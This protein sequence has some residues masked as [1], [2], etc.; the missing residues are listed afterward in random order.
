MTK[1]VSVVVTC[2]NHQAYIK[3][4]L[5]SLFDQ[6]YSNIELLVFN[7]GSTDQSG[8]IIQET[9]KA[10][11]FAV[12][13]YHEHANQGIVKTRNQAFD[14]IQGDYLLFV[15]SDNYLPLNFIESVVTTAE[16]AQA[17]LVYTA[18][19]NADDGT[20][21]NPIR[22]FDL[23]ELYFGNYMDNCSLVRVSAIKTARYDDQLPKLVDYDF[24]MNLIIKQGAKAVACPDTFIHYRV[25]T[26]SISAHGNVKKYYRAYSYILGKY[27]MDHPQLAYRALQKHFDAFARAEQA[28]IEASIR[29]EQFS[30]YV[31]DDK[32]HEQTLLWQQPVLFE[33]SFELK[34]GS[35]IPQLR[36][37]P[38]RIPSFY[39]VL[40]VTSK[41]YGT[42]L[43]P[44][45]TNGTM[46]AQ[47]FVFDDFHPYIDY[48]LTFYQDDVLQVTYQRYNIADITSNSQPYI[49]TALAK[50]LKA[51]TAQHHAA[52]LETA[53][54]FQ[55]LEV[56]HT[57]ALAKKQ[58]ELDKL[59]VAYD[60]LFAQYH[61]T[62]GSRRWIYPTKLLN[63]LRRKK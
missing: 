37:L 26:T 59:Q 60:Q 33:E 61:A 19:V 20:V 10:S 21:V 48:D 35:E 32:E 39:Q 55:T 14:Q 25:L 27:Y 30:A 51:Q 28:D 2:Y 31:L 49:G 45:R 4:C 46:V 16:K 3:E 40:T 52:E 13:R 42:R 36:L 56:R 18:L 57:E 53:Q 8:A 47:G 24:F 50:A 1:L 54:V 62:I 17:D 38:S 41:K 29:Q 44:I 7:D 11:P 12:T 9:L 6:T 43:Q 58:A 34:I 23:A 22:A 15:D 5:E 63:F